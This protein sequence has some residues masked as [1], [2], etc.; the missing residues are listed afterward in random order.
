MIKI[1]IKEE[2]NVVNKI[3]FHGHAMYDDYGKDIVC[4]GVSSILTTTVNAILAFDEEAISFDDKQDFILTILKDDKITNTLIQN[5]ISL[6]EE[7]TESYPK[8]IQIRKE[9]AK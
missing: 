2:N 6:L 3:V 1:T 7:L 8:N 5:M 9:E 4:A